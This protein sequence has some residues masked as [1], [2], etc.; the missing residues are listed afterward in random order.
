VVQKNASKEITK[1]ETKINKALSLFRQY[2]KDAE[3][4]NENILL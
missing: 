4:L 2:L 1:L 3:L